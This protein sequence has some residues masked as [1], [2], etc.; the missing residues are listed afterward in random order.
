MY[1]LIELFV[2]KIVLRALLKI[3]TNLYP[4]YISKQKCWFEADGGKKFF[5]FGCNLERVYVWQQ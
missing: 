5:L 3:Y 2:I 1:I 4:Y